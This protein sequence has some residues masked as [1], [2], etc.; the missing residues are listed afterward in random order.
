[1]GFV[2]GL[3]LYLTKKQP[4]K[5]YAIGIVALGLCFLALAGA[6][7]WPPFA[8]AVAP[9]YWFFFKL[10]WVLYIFI[11]VRGTFPRYRYDQLMNIGWKVM[12]PTALGAVFV[13]A[14]VGMLRG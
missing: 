13:N 3:C 2:G 10:F 4:I 9:A 8:Q 6:F 11:W 1:M 12:I 14:V 5:G 7:L